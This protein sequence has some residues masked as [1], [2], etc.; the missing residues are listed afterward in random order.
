MD[1]KRRRRHLTRR[2]HPP[3]SKSYPQETE[4]A[5]ITLTD[6]AEQ[7]LGISCA[8]V[9]QESVSRRRTFGGE[10]M[11]PAGKSIIVSAPVA[12]EIVTSRPDCDAASWAKRQG[13]RAGADAGPPA[14]ARTLRADAGRANPNGQRPRDTHVR[15]TVARG[16]VQRS[17]AEVEAAEIAMRRAEQLLSDKAGSAKAVD[18]TR[19]NPER[20]STRPGSR[21]R[22]AAPVR[23]NY[24]LNWTPTTSG[25][26]AVP[27]RMTSPQSG[28]IR[29]LTVTPGQTVNVGTALF[30]VVDISSMWIR[31]PV[32]VGYC[33]R[34]KL[35]ADAQIVGLDGRPIAT[36]A[37]SAADRCAALRPTC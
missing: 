4:I 27:L 24:W 6:T 11:I 33:R 22:T 20:R 26:T 9:T 14:L 19:A 5:R 16:D 21:R 36:I 13:R 37:A 32:Y 12:G 1:V 34:S 31:V 35:Q 18:D 30:E 2:N 3:K 29:S 23:D 28:V 17:H 8:E 10:V 15:L 7:R 25:G